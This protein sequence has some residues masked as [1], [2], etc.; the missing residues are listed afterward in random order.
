MKYG[1]TSFGPSHPDFGGKISTARLLEIW[2]KTFG[3]D[4]EQ[5]FSSSEVTLEPVP[6]YGYLRFT[7]S[8]G[9]DSTF[10]SHLMRKMGYDTAEKAEFAR[11]ALEISP[12]DRVL[13][14]GSGI[15]NFATV[16]PGVYSGIDT[17]PVAITDG[18]GLGR[19]VRLGMVEN[20]T[21]ESCDVVTLFQVLEHVEEPR[22]FLQACIRCLRPGRRLIVS[23]PNM[24]GI[25][26]Y[27][28]NEILNYPPHHMTWWSPPALQALLKDCGCETLKVWREPLQRIHVPSALGALFFPRGSGHHY[29][30]LR[31]RLLTF[32]TKVLALPIKRKWTEVPFI[33]GHTMMIVAT[34]LGS[35]D[36]RG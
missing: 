12:E 6:P 14:V 5:F 11:A 34:K 3:L 30:W 17:N 32:A 18:A 1:S 15:G 24:E 16:C 22:Q 36:L 25:L 21:P 28:P 7:S 27:V 33:T 13:D 35:N 2:E 4:V 26:G 19:N 23:T 10:Y 31:N 20:E 9:G 29:S 8:R